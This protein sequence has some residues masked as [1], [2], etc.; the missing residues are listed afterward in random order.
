MGNRKR[1]M[2]T[3]KNK[4]KKMITK[5]IA[6]EAIDNN[7]GTGVYKVLKVQHIKEKRSVKIEIECFRCGSI[8]EYVYNYL[9]NNEIRCLCSNT[10][11]LKKMAKNYAKGLYIEPE[12][13][14]IVGNELL[15]YIKQ[16]LGYDMPGLKDCMEFVEYVEDYLLDIYETKR[17]TQC[18]RCK[19]YY[20]AKYVSLGRVCYHCRSGVF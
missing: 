8:E 6:Q 9:I 2:I 10:E 18:K 3:L 16:S 15:D 1:G 5:D 11:G 19:G 12:Q 4:N 13:G 17:A 14:L 7:Y 20:P